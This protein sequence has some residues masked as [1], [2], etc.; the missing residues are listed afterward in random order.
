MIMTPEHESKVEA[1]P[2]WAA[3]DLEALTAL[4]G[5]YAFMAA[6]H[7]IDEVYAALGIQVTAESAELHERI[8]KIASRVSDELVAHC[9]RQLT[10]GERDGTWEVERVI[11]ER[12]RGNPGAWPAEPPS[13]RREPR[14]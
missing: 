6:E 9:R 10:E 7:T 11:L 13:A 4:A 5:G 1:Y 2:E 14:R 3:D 8:S 12:M